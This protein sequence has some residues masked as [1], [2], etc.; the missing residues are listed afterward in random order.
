MEKK[1]NNIIFFDGV[2][3]VCDKTVDFIITKDKKN[4]FFYSSL[5]SDFSKRF[6]KSKNQKLNLESIVVYTEDKFLYK[7]RGMIYILKN[8]VGFPRIIGLLLNIFPKFISDYFYS[9]FAKYRYKL[10]GKMDVCKIPTE[11]H[12]SRFYE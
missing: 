12:F 5:Q 2:C 1:Y 8:L 10:F 3:N 9:L 6:F 11:N 7:S 4:E